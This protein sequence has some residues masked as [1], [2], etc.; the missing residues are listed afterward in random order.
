[1]CASRR[2][3]IRRTRN[4]VFETEHP[5]WKRA[6]AITAFLKKAQ[7]E[8]KP[9]GVL[10]SVDV[11]GVMAW[12]RQ[13]D[14]S[15]TGQDIP[16]MAKY[17]DVMS[18]MIYPIAL[19]RHGRVHLTGRRTG[20]LHRRVDGAIPEG[21]GGERR[22]AASMVAGLWLENQELLSRVHSRSGRGLAT[23]KGQTASCSGTPTTITA[24]HIRRCR[25]CDKTRQSTSVA[26]R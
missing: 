24:S 25:R 26:T 14:L 1:M 10:F 12:Q 6:D 3:A 2:K 4:S 15:H 16:Q 19:L 17:C 13:I 21:D 22:G 20:A 9:M 8:L 18:P 23:A 11:F 5:D 7:S